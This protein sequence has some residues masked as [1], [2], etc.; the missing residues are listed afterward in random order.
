[1]KAF[2]FAVGWGSAGSGLFDG[3]AGGGAGPVP[4]SGAVAGTVVGEYSFGDDPD[5]GLP[6]SRSLPEP[7]SSDGLFV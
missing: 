2:N 1:V 4:E 5:R 7:G 6:G 3:G